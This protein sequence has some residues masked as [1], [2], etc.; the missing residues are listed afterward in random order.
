MNHQLNAVM[1][2]LNAKQAFLGID[3]HISVV[4]CTPRLW[5]GCDGVLLVF[6]L[7]CT[8]FLLQNI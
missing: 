5:Q 1:H 2:I 8:K 4:F 7:I 6:C 3:Y